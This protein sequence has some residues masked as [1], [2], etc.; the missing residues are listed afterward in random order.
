MHKDIIT[1][2]LDEP[3]GNPWARLP[4]PPRSVPLSARWRLLTKKGGQKTPFQ[5]GIFLLVWS[6]AFVSQMSPRIDPLGTWRLDRSARTVPGRIE[7]V[8]SAHLKL[9]DRPVFRVEYT[10]RPP[11]GTPLRGVSFTEWKEAEGRNAVVE[12]SPK[13]P[14]LNR[15]QG[16][17]TAPW[18]TGWLLLLAVFPVIGL[19]L[20]GVGTRDGRKRIRLLV[21]GLSTLA[22]VESARFTQYGESGPHPYEPFAD[23]QPWLEAR[24][25]VAQRPTLKPGGCLWIGAAIAVLV[26]TLTVCGFLFGLSLNGKVPMRLV[27]RPIGKGMAVLFIASCGIATVV[28]CVMMIVQGGRWHAVALADDDRLAVPPTPLHLDCRFVFETAD[29][30]GIQADDSAVFLVEPGRRF[31]ARQWALYDPRR[32][33]RAVLTAGLGDGPFFSASRALPPDSEA[34]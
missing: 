22:T 32:P 25:G 2:F 17:R 23:I 4:P 10:F 19:V 3:G 34:T 15:I 33:T 6:L 21:H 24:P 18:P 28:L 5:F 7:R 26:L 13:N 16:M 8:E 14:N 20:I 9:N 11:G 31:E 1:E 29:G 12:Y 30:Q 27:G